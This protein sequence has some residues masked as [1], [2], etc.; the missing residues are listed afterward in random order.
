MSRAEDF[1]EYQ[2]N[3]DEIKK[4]R[5]MIKDAFCH[6]LEAIDKRIEILDDEE[7]IELTEYFRH[8]TRN[9]DWEKDFSV[10]A[11]VDKMKAFLLLFS[12]MCHDNDTNKVLSYFEAME[13]GW[14]GGKYHLNNQCLRHLL[15]SPQGCCK[16]Q[17]KI[18]TTEL[19]REILGDIYKIFIS[20]EAGQT[21]LF[22]FCY[23]LVALF[24]TR[25]NQE[26]FSVPFFLQIACDR[27][28]VLYQFIEEIVEICDVNSGL[29]DHCNNIGGWYGY[30][31][32]KHQV[33]YPTQAVSHDM[34]VLCQ[35]KDIPVIISG[36]ENER[37]YHALLRQTANVVHKKSAL[38][39]KDKFNFLPVF[40]CQ[41]IKSSFDN[42][43]NMD[44]TEFD[45][46]KK[47]LAL[48]RKRKK[49]LASWSV[50]LVM[51][52]GRYLFSYDSDEKKERVK[53]RHLLSSYLGEYINY[54]SQMYPYLTLQNAKNVGFL[55]F[56]FKGYMSVFE[57]SCTFP[58]EEEFVFLKVN[59]VPMPQNRKINIGSL[60]NFSENA[61]AEFHQRYLPAPK[62]TGVKNKDAV[63]L[64]KQIEKHYRS[65]KVSIRVT[66]AEVK[67]DRYIF[68]VDAL[69]ETKVADISKNA[70]NVKHRLK[71]YECFRADL[72][73]L[74]SIK[75][76]VA[77]K[78]LTDNSLIEIL[79]HKDFANSK[80]KIP[81]AV[82]FDE[83]GNICIEDI[84]NLMHLLLG[85]AT[86]TG[87]STALMSLLMSI[88][89]KHRT[90]NV[91]VLIMDLLGKTESDFS[92]FNDQPF[93]S[94][95]VITDPAMAINAILYLQEE[96]ER[97]LQMKRLSEMP[98]I[99]C[100]ID[101]YPR[102]FFALS[103][104]KQENDIASVISDLLSSSRHSNIHLI[105]SAQNPV[106]EYIKGNI[107][108]ITARMA[109]RCGHYQNSK[110]ILGRGGAEKLIG[111]GQMIFDCITERD[112]RIQGA[113]ISE[114]DMRMLLAEIKKDFKQQNKYPF[115]LDEME[116][117]AFSVAQHENP[118]HVDEKLPEVILWALPQSR[119]ANSRIQAQ[120]GVANNRANRL[121]SQM[122]EWKLIKKLHGNL[123]WELIPG[124]YEDLPIEVINCLVKYG[125]TED[126]IR[127]ILPK[128][129]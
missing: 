128:K 59:G 61:L 20:D 1:P 51:E 91:N 47:Q 99:V 111:R 13:F 76:I 129:D 78:Q 65:L 87:K 89:Y 106:K 107:A 56:F 69:N 123:G 105:L 96:K 79:K 116:E 63:R 109:F 29:F 70:E 24:S 82:G 124:C 90:G 12:N 127:R 18:P 84:D 8:L 25:L 14:H 50:E 102:L 62:S 71:I 4:M 54:V 35:N 23:C 112:R 67:E 115:R 10:D 81:Y 2:Q 126:E 19:A 34:D 26:G 22:I 117:H 11:V 37:Y 121:L 108:N 43:F 122:E 77:E 100:I 125:K 97:R 75:L 21:M 95:P 33:Y 86:S 57:K 73:D 49:M 7:I 58:L 36:H 118:S 5:R 44:L 88:A 113:Y 16:R 119:V 55:N 104:K 83:S 101:E 48:L 92:I 15:Y 98:H 42:V 80:M 6:R 38:D 32:Y 103:N 66:P 60:T 40:I 120:F 114:K 64:A 45:I 85:G 28:S 46:S 17:D 31:G 68:T 93:L 39:W 74:A 94:A 27:S 41:E 3:S 52:S 53:S 9:H 72:R 30:C 110:A